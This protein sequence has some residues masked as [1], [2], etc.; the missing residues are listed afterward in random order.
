MM[1]SVSTL[2]PCRHVTNHHS[3]A[4]VPLAPGAPGEPDALSGICS[5]LRTLLYYHIFDFPLT[6]DELH[7]LSDRRWRNRDEFDSAVAELVGRGVLRRVGPYCVV[8]DL[9]AVERRRRAEVLARTVLPA[10]RRRARLIARFPWVLS[11]SI[12]GTL[13]KA[14]HEADDDVDFF[15]ITQPGRL[16]LCR[17]SL[18][19]F[20]K[21]VLLNSR[22]LFC[23]NYLLTSDR[24]EVPDRNLFTATELAWLH[25]VVDDGLYRALLEANGWLHDLLPN[26]SARDEAP[27]PRP[28]RTVGPLVERWLGGPL[29][30]RLDEGSRRLISWRNRRR[31]RALDPERYDQAMRA[32][33][34]VSKHHPRDFQGAILTRYA[35]LLREAEA[36]WGLLLQREGQA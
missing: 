32:T 16:W 24:L 30:D 18:M 9:A 5:V 17:A 7:R 15:V 23:V 11:V 21:T 10:A 31:Y 26:W 28:P 2:R 19:A 36:R 3:T 14:V 34:E 12:S 29:G 1:D 4:A 35:A 8:G 6:T 27:E 25:P 13:S 22:K 20:K 33:P